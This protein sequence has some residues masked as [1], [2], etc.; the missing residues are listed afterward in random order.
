MLELQASEKTK[1]EERTPDAQV[2]DTLVC[3]SID[4]AVVRLD[5]IEVHLNR[6]ATAFEAALTEFHEELELDAKPKGE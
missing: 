6:I 2:C 3:E 1:T 4:Q 5:E